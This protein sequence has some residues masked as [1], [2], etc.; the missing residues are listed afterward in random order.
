[1]RV[2]AV[3]LYE[4][5]RREDARLAALVKEIAAETGHDVDTGRTE[6]GLAM[7]PR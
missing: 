4:A 5:R 1:V 6:H 3:S 2:V 7:V